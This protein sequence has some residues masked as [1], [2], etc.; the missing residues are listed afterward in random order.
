MGSAFNRKRMPLPSDRIAPT[1]PSRYNDFNPDPHETDLFGSTTL[2]QAVAHD[3]PDITY[4]KILLEKDSSCASHKNQFN[5][6][7]LHYVLDRCNVSY[8]AVKLLMKHFPDGA[9][10]PDD[11]GVTP[12]TL[13]NV[14][15]I[16]VV[17]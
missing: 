11:D 7:P 8:E 14:I 1:D 17:C 6:I 16:Y 10:V 5:R 4:M 15:Y 13:T 3:D 12:C 2:H 9:N